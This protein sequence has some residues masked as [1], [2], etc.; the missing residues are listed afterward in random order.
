MEHALSTAY[1][2]E[3]WNFQG[4]H[5]EYIGTSESLIEVVSNPSIG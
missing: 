2:P 1:H 4:L 5:W 3:S